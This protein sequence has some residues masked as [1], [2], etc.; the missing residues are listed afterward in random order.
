MDAR[1]SEF[2]GAWNPSPDSSNLIALSGFCILLV[3]MLLA[4]AIDLASCRVSGSWKMN[5]S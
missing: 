3:A 5:S 2:L 1:F 4:L